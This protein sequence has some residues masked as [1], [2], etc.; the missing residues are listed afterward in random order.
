M[1]SP[2][3]IERNKIYSENLCVLCFNCGRGNGMD[4]V[5]FLETQKAGSSREAIK[6]AERMGY[7]TVLFTNRISFKEKRGD[8][9]DVHLLR[10]LD[11]SDIELIR[12]E[13]NR[14]ILNGINVKGIVSF[15][16]P[17]VYTSC[18]L[19]DEF[20]INHFTTESI[21]HMQN[22]I[23]SRGTLAGT[24]Y[25]PTYSILE[26]DMNLN[27]LMEE[28]NTWPLPI[29][30]SPYS[31]G[32]KD[33]FCP[34]NM[35]ELRLFI[36]KLRKRNPSSSIL[37]EEY[38]HGP[39]YLVEAV[40]QNGQLKI[41]AVFE[42]EINFKERFIITGYSL[43][44]NLNKEFFHHMEHA[45]DE[46]I[47]LHDFKD[48]ACHLEMRYCNKQWKL[49]EINPRISG[50]AMNR[51][52]ELGLGINL[53]EEELKMAMGITPDFTVKHKKP[54]FTQYVTVDS[55]GTLLKVTGKNKALA[56][57][58]VEEV[59]VKPKKGALLQPP[60]SMGH[61]YAYVIAT[62]DTEEEAKQNA[63]EAATYLR[64]YIE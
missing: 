3:Q 62:G 32:S 54:V 29:V 59:Y 9:P 26:P 44:H 50:G 11:L 27:Y 1:T 47:K 30:K 57:R 35:D 24:A 5:I 33:V 22:K 31:T 41:I 34:T 10:Y 37:L 13:I 55:I 6:A 7:Y 64:F 56:S 38:L 14:L 4:T 45:V 2:S 49:I 17:Y 52:I 19:A 58:G 43:K 36:K 8:F 42:Q 39:Q 46:I 23:A 40:V 16:D 21:K 25:S 28:L 18:L 12:D 15:V 63:K 61:R 51:M 20:G 60:R 48:G 53:V